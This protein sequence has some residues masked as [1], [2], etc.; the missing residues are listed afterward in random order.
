MPP[1]FHICDFTYLGVSWFPI[2]MVN[3]YP[4]FKNQPNVISSLKSSLTLP[5][6]LWCLVCNS[7]HY[8]ILSLTLDGF[9]SP[10]DHE[11]F[12]SRDSLCSIYEFPRPNRVSGIIKC[13]IKMWW[14]LKIVSPCQRVHQ[15]ERSWSPIAKFKPYLHLHPRQSWIK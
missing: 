1:L 4:S 13:L 6:T 15:Q 12:W 8:T 11:L 9:L 14:T 5:N 10:L 3:F 2:H 7:T